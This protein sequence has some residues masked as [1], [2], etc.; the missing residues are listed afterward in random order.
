MEKIQYLMNELKLEPHPEGGFYR[1]VYKSDEIIKELPSRFDGP[2]VFSTAIYF[3]LTKNTFSAFHIIKQDEIWHHYE[4]GTI[5][6][7]VLDHAGEYGSY[8]LGKNY[9][10]G[11][12]LLVVIPKDT[13]FAAEV[14]EGEYVLSGC[15]VA[16]GFEY[17][18]FYMPP[19]SEL[20]IMF[21]EYRQLIERLTK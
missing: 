5:K 19:V 12:E 17:E 6:I 20:I 3:L 1:Q 21:P 18:D 16:P 2:R 11:E 9:D 13:F 8:L 7:H 14:I 4:G 10:A 15:T